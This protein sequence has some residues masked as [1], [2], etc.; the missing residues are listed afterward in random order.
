MTDLKIGGT[1][2]V[3]RE[4]AARL[5]RPP[6]VSVQV[7]CL[8]RAGPM[9]DQIRARGIQVT[10]L[11]AT[12]PFDF[13]V[14][15]RL[16][17][18]IRQ[19]EFDTV[20][21]FLVHANAIAAAAWLRCSGVRFLQSIQTTQ[22][23]PKWHWWVQRLAQRTAESV[24]VPS[25]AV[26][27]VATRWA[28]VAR[29]KICVIPNGIDPSEY[30][31]APPVELKHEPPHRVV[32]I[33]RL[34]PIKRIPDL[35][36]AVAQLGN[37]VKLDI[38]GEGPQRSLLLQQ[39]RKL[40]IDDV[41]H[42]RGPI[43]DPRQA[44]RDAELLVL[45]SEAE[46]FGLVLIEAMAAGVP[47]VATDVPGINEVVKNGVTGTL[48]PVGSPDRL[49]SAMQKVLTDANLRRRLVVG[50]WDDVRQRFTWDMAMAKYRDLLGIDLT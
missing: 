11:N 38:F 44:L 41:V 12:G 32:F 2:T 18:L 14:A 15:N 42:L 13:L 9:A 24:I 21:S 17:R 23:R 5:L 46:G 31:A 7:A 26:A 19:N 50:A 22:P 6:A 10:A 27:D 29:S 3:A 1:P 49:A 37:L 20:I 28:G 40:N 4:L 36:Q 25:E 48:V 16:F 33:G 35:L 45:P 47:V 8:D 30:P 39:L 43:S 34:D